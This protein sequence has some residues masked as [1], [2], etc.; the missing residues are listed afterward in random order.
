MD[1]Q[2]N[3]FFKDN[4]RALKLWH[5]W[6]YLAWQDVISK[7]RR[8]ILGPLWIAGGMVS[9]SLAISISL[10]A[11]SGQPLR[12]FLP[13]A[14]AGILVW[15]HFI[16]ILISEAPEIFVGAQ[17]SI[18]NNAFPFMFYVFRFATR[19]L[20]IFLHNIV[21]L[22]AVMLSVKNVHV[23]AWQVIPAVFLLTAF[24]MFTAPIVG[25]AAA[26]FRD[27]RFLLP[28]TAQILFFITPV[29]W[30]PST[31]AA[32]K[33]NIVKYNPLYYLVD[34]LR[35]PLLGEAVVANAWLVSILSLFVVVIIWAV[36]FA[37]FRRRIAFWI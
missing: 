15:T 16:G 19:S 34:I 12:E 6:S 32:S 7:Y 20:I 24:M 9:T 21:V 35:A 2:I 25:M 13:F 28:Y 18:K 8:S 17:G 4:A 14:M 23:P 10:G 29:F 26:R 11:M 3:L 27:L 30:R 36:S 1:S 33:I 5:V 37:A 31:L 22:F